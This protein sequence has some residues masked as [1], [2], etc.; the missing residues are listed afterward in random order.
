MYISIYI[1]IYI[2]IYIY[3]NINIYKPPLSKGLE[4]GITPL[5]PRGFETVRWGPNQPPP[6]LFTMLKAD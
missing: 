5:V 1:C 2:Y 4:S 6:S 3:T